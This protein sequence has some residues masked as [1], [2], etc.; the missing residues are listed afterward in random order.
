MKGSMTAGGTSRGVQTA[1][2]G[3]GLGGWAA[4]QAQIGRLLGGKLTQ[5]T[6]G[7]AFA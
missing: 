2:A 6:V 1:S 5:E 4:P 3:S 7:L